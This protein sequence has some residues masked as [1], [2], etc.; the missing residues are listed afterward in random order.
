MPRAEIASIAVPVL[1]AVGTKDDIAGQA[2]PL[3]DIIPG[4]RVLDI[5]DRDHMRAVGDRVFKEGV[6]AFLER[7]P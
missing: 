6:L 4:A 2:R 7:R 1:V 3:A 5:P